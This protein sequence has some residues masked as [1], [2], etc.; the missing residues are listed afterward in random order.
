VKHL[1]YVWYAT[2]GIISNSKTRGTTIEKALCF[3]SGSAWL[4]LSVVTVLYV[5]VTTPALRQA[6]GRSTYNAGHG[7]HNRS[8]LER[9]PAAA[10]SQPYRHLAAHVI[11]L[12]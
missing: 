9:A 1:M 12:S 10:L 8:F 6:E 5:S 2:F 7:Y 11:S 4:L 3:A